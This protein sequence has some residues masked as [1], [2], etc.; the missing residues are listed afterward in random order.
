[1]HTGRRAWDSE[2]S[3]IDST[4]LLAG[5][6]GSAVYFGRETPEENE[7]RALADELYRRADTT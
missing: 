2:F 4:F 7:V 5:A 6:L 1:M 3:T